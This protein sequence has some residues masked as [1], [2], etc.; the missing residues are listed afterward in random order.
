[1][2]GCVD[3]IGA[4]DAL[5]ILGIVRVKDED[6]FARV[7]FDHTHVFILGSAL[8]RRRRRLAYSIDEVGRVLHVW[9]DVVA[10]VGFLERV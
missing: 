9:P 3:A 5:L 10:D 2:D 8:L 7:V 6:L 4:Q 1:M